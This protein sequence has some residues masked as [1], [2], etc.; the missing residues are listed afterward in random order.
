MRRVP[1]IIALFLLTAGLA[2]SARAAEPAPG[3]AVQAPATS[4]GAINATLRE[5]MKDDAPDFIRGQMELIAKDCSGDAA[6]VRLIKAYRYISARTRRL[7]ASSDYILDPSGLAARADRAC[8]IGRIC[9]EDGVCVLL[10]Y[11]STGY[12]QWEQDFVQRAA[13]WELMPIEGPRGEDNLSA[14]RLYAPG[15]CL[16]A[17]KPPGEG[18][19]AECPTD[20]IWTDTG[21]RRHETPAIPA[22]AP[23]EGE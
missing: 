23:A 8:V 14:L 10:G 22:A 4:N 13:R 12:Q 1:A 9:A 17:Q 11:R 3:A 20:Y 19:A 2:A 21:L 7:N 16:D 18:G 15:P 6:N 5:Q